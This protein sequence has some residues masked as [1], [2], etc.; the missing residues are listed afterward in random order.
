MIGH[1]AAGF[2]G[3]NERQLAAIDRI[4]RQ[5]ALELDV[6]ALGR[7]VAL[8]VEE[9]LDAEGASVLVQDREGL[10]YVG[11]TG[12]AARGR[13]GAVASDVVSRGVFESGEAVLVAEAGQDPRF[14][15]E[16]AAETGF[17]T[18]TLV[19]APLVVRG[20]TIGVVEAVNRRG[21]RPFGNDDL[22]F[23]AG[24]APHVSAAIAN[25]LTA[26]ALR[27]SRDELARHNQELEKKIDERTRLIG[28]AK[29][30]WEQTFDAIEEPLSLVDGFR[31]RRA[32]KAWANAAQ[33]AIRDVPGRTCHRALFGR[34][35]P[36]PGCPVLSGSGSGRRGEIHIDR[37]WFV[38]TAF[39][40]SLEE[41]AKGGTWVVGYR[42][43]TE[44][45]RIAVRLRE[46]ERQGAVARLAAGAAHEINNPMAFVAAG[47]GTL[48]EH[49]DE[50]SE[51]A[52]LGLKVAHRG[53]VGLEPALVRE[54][55]ALAARVD[56]DEAAHLHD[57]GLAVIA[58]AEEGVRRVTTIVRA[59]KV[60]GPEEV[61]GAERVELGSLVDRA[62]DRARRASSGKEPPRW[63]HR[64]RVWVEGRGTQLDQAIFEV[65][66]NAYQ[67]GS[68]SLSCRQTNGELEFEVRDDG[69]GV[70]AELREQVFEPFFTTRGVGGGVGLGLTVAA[71][72]LRRHGG[73]IEVLDGDGRGTLVRIR[74]PLARVEDELAE[75]GGMT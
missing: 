39:S 30:E 48:R 51:W 29:R 4:A 65:I 49:L 1:F 35:D 62:A 7:A 10:R 19:A 21:G 70:P 27:R 2:G 12:P 42:D 60:L 40:L 9:A 8:A 55:G 15:R 46:A 45:R 5:I 3:P 53:G 47:L 24:L 18:R 14:E 63:L 22:R 38:V 16:R 71:G 36:C 59:L 56:A 64:D 6:G 25:A 68:V 54:L 57:D 75:A 43:I 31:V 20:T 61:G 28:T 37:A 13:D 32:N 67:A 58:D 72:V 23:L 11:A 44:E 69:P 74:L 34:D 52:T 17:S 50:L 73:S 33:L 66:R 41:G 26:E